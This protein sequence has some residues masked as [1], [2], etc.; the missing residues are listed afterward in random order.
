MPE[1]EIIEVD[2]KELES[3][4]VNNIGSIAN[5]LEKGD[6]K[7]IGRQLRTDTGP[8]DIL[9]IDDEG[10]LIVFELKVSEDDNQ[11]DQGL[12]YF[13][14]VVSDIEWIAR[15]Y[16]AEKINIGKNPE[17]ILI[18]PSFSRN[19]RKIAKYISEGV[20]LSLLTCDVVK[21]PDGKKSLIFKFFELERPLES[22]ILPTEPSV[23]SI[24]KNE[25]MKKLFLQCL[26]E[27]KSLKLEI[28]PHRDWLSVFYMGERIASMYPRVKYPFFWFQGKR[29][30]GS[31]KWHKVSSEESWRKI[32]NDEVLPTYE[33]RGG[34]RPSTS[35]SH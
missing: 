27:L 35:E 33:S 25:E 32:F 22:R 13:D 31:E 19:L 29:P 5:V 20:G 34:I 3:L 9:A 24:I 14:W 30:D 12:R 11:L 1:I 28:R 6:I 2:E 4:V 21:L 16:P 23:L 8:L 7:V 18:A 26:N 17:L 15:A 10:V